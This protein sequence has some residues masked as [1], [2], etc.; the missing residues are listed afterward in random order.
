[1]QLMYAQS[2]GVGAIEISIKYYLISYREASKYVTFR[3]K[4]K[5]NLLQ[6]AGWNSYYSTFG[7]V[8]IHTRLI[9]IINITVIFLYMFFFYF[10]LESGHLS[11]KHFIFLAHFLS[12]Q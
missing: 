9:I 10:C 8:I 2:S 6:S 5:S 1:M 7:L 4:S 11:G 12:L 3:L